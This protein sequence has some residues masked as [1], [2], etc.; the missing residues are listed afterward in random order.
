M[1]HLCPLRLR[2]EHSYRFAV[3]QLSEVLSCIS[4]PRAAI[5][6]RSGTWGH[7]KWAKA[8]KD[9][10]KVPIFGA[11]IAVVADMET[12]EKQDTCWMVFL[13]R[14]NKG[15]RELNELMTLATEYFYFYPRLDYGQLEK[16]SEN[17]FILSGANPNVALVPKGLK[18]FYVELNELTSPNSFSLKYP[19]VATFDNLYPRPED[20]QLYEVIVGE[21]RQ[22]ST[23]PRH[24]LSVWD[25]L[26]VNGPRQAIDVANQIAE[27]CN[28]DL[29]QATLVKPKVKKTLR[30]MCLDGAITRKL[31]VTLNRQYKKRLET[32]LSLIKEKEFEDYFFVVADMINWAK[33]RM[34]V[35]PARGSSCGS[36]VCYLIGITDIDPIPYDLLFERFIDINRKD[37]PDIDIDFADDKRE[38]VFEYLREKYG[39][40][41]VTRLGT[42]NVFKA[43]SALGDCAKELSVPLWEIQDLKNS[44]I[45]RSSGDSRATF[46]IL[47]TF[48]QLESGRN[49]LAKYPELRLSARMEGHAR[50]TGMHAAAIIV[51]AKPITNYCA[52]NLKTGTAMLDKKDAEKLNLLKIDALGL[53]TLSVLDDALVAVG[54]SREWLRAYPHDDPKTFAIINAK[55]F[56]GIFQFEGYAL[57]SVSKQFKVEN[58][59][60]VA[61]LT[62]LAR[63]GP[64]SSGGTTNWLKRRTGVEKAKYVHPMTKEFTKGTYGVV[65]YQEQV[66]KIAREIGNMS[67]NDVSALRIIMAKTLGIEYFNTFWD[68]F[69]EGAL[70]NGIEEEQAKAIWDDICTMGSWAFNRAHSIAYGHI[71]Y[72]CL[73]MK[74]NFPLEFAAACLR[75]AKDDDQ[76]IKILRELT[77]EGFKYRPFDRKLSALNW[78]TNEGVLIGGITAIKGVGPALAASILRKRSNGQAF[79]PREEKLLSEGTTPWDR[80]FECAERWGHIVASPEKYNV[81]SVIRTI[82]DMEQD[83]SEVFV[84]IAKIIEKNLRDHNEVKS[85]EKRGGRRIADPTVFLNLTL[86]DDT[87]SIPATVNRF[88]YPEWGLPIVEHGKVGDWYLWKG[89]HQAG[90]H[91]IQVTRWKKLTDN[92]QF[93]RVERKVKKVVAG[94]DGKHLINTVQTNLTKKTKRKTA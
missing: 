1:T 90:I 56:A 78:T 2:T 31:D 52:V 63:P 72:Y 83:T 91:R 45:E 89:K 55:H 39:H 58:F 47:D 19:L 7:V 34:F 70:A 79:T 35:G 57:Q 50:H 24:I 20:R 9:A 82:G 18:T 46:C 28:A 62:A 61:A 42:V 92:Q 80:V 27:Q 29:P 64:L 60:D 41:Q 40:D 15:L 76:S 33:E 86:E 93:A 68:K 6:D 21:Q 69:K 4:A 3:G 65:V 54:K 85:I 74:A 11:E 30:Q 81:E 13:A 5:T 16:I 94:T 59:E 38:L 49:I 17:V 36:L 53:R 25:W 88:D 37:L 87:G 77:M 10:G 67:W 44:I 23:V 71:S 66:M 73:V 48:E 84:F 51:T 75:N 14:N 32:E 12:R 43:K 22:M 26:A 8:C